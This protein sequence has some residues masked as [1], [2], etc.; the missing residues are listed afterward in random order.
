MR[1]T[2]LI[3]LIVVFCLSACSDSDSLNMDGSGKGG[4]MSRFAISSSHL[5]IVTPEKLIPFDIRNAWEPVKQSEIYLGT[6]IE[7]VFPYEHYLFIGSESGM[8]IYD[9]AQPSAPSF[10]SSYW[11][12]RSCDPVVVQGSYAYVT[13]RSTTACMGATNALEVIDISDLKNPQLINSYQMPSPHGLGID[14][15]Y[16]FVCNG[17]SGFT[18]FDASDPENITV[19]KEFDDHHSYDLIMKN[20]LMIVT[21]NDGLYQYDYK[22]ADSLIFLSHINVVKDGI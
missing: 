22:T 20:G 14:G 12:V 7:T 9:I 15:S 4:S 11:H 13:L 16:L 18:A 2:V 21:G 1:T 3:A 10:V 5:Y 19:K 6:D 8:R 17:D